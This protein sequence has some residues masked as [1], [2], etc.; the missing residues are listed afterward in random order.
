MD[1]SH[2]IA[3]LAIKKDGYTNSNGGST[4]KCGMWYVTRCVLISN[5][6]KT[7]NSAE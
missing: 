3:V 7:L 1:S 5:R 2:F 4:N 6:N